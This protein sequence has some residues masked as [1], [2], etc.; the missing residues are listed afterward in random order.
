MPADPIGALGIS[1]GNELTQQ[2]FNLRD[3]FQ[4]FEDVASRKGER[5]ELLRVRG[6]AGRAADVDAGTF[7][8][9][10]RGLDL[11]ERQRTAAKK[12]I[13]L[14]RAI[15]QASRT[16][17]VRRGF[18]DRATKAKQAGVGFSDLIFGQNLG[19]QVSEANIF[20]QKTAADA[21]RKA[22]KKA[23]KLGTLSTLAG[24]ALAAFGSSE[25]H[26][27][28]DGEAEGLLEK[29]SKVRVERWN[30]KGSRVKHI[31][32]FSEEFNAAFNVGKDN[33]SM[34][35]LIDALGVT[36]GAVKELDRKVEARG[37]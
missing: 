20:G 8:R 34:I 5:E 14:T 31:G 12:R 28:K 25:A 33:P 21:Q 13:G 32:P 7:S 23:A 26:K 3:F 15:A 11:S 4:Q 22:D 37:L 18:T 35:N 27:D 16:G 19:Q 30:Y 10:T 17:D 24:L 29:L 2:N 36:L 1:A 6:E 9:Q